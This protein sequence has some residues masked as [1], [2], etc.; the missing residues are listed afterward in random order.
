MVRRSGAQFFV[1]ELSWAAAEPAPHRYRVEEITRA[2]RVLRQSGAVLHLDLPLVP[3][4]GARRPGG[5]G[6]GRVR[7]SEALAPPRRPSRRVEAGASRFPDGFARRRR[8]YLLRR[9]AR[10]APG[11]SAPL[12]RRGQLLEEESAEAARRRDDGGAHGQPGAGGRR[13]PAPAQPAAALHLLP[14]SSGDRPSSSAIP[15]FSTRTGGRSSAAP[16]AGRSRFPWSATPRRP[17]TA[18]APRGRPSSFA[19]SRTFSGRPTGG[20]FSSRVTSS[21]ATRP[22]K[23]PAF[24]RTPPRRRSA[25]ARFSRTGAS[26]SSTASPSRRGVSGFAIR[27]L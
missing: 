13:R 2:A 3:R 5:S 19:A 16:A 26:R 14:P 17:R 10:R 23:S 11:L 4:G 20:R 27:G 8:R 15:R 1:L 21:C 18:R 24:R 25:A 22:A 9:Q 12:R 7:R 6:A